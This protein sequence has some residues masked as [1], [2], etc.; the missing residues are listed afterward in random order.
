MGS[1]DRDD[2]PIDAIDMIISLL[3]EH[4][5]T[6]DGLLHR[7]EEALSLVVQEPSPPPGPAPRAAGVSVVLKDWADF[8]KRCADTGT[9]CFV[10]DGGS[11]KVSAIADGVLYVYE[12]E[13]PSLDI[14]Y[15][16]EGERLRIEGFEAEFVGLVLKVL[17][18]RLDCGLE[19]STREVETERADGKLARRILCYVEVGAARA[20]L[21]SE[22]G[23][24][25]ASILE[26]E[27][28][29]RERD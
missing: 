15:E 17:R 9:V 22:M 16:A 23:I 11:F 10:V 28:M 13:I 18:R 14:L 26:G 20:W 7:I 8:R 4:E 2:R 3:K 19:F 1:S 29:L 21:A 6:L 27:L 5:K 12:E 25:R 24:S